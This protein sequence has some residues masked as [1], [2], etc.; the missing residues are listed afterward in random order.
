MPL[1]LSLRQFV[2]QHG[3]VAGVLVITLILLSA[4]FE[5]Y[6]LKQ[7]TLAGATF[8]WG[9][10]VLSLWVAVPFTKLRIFAASIV[11]VI[12]LTLLLSGVWAD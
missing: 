7:R 10:T 8:V 4:W 3:A 6:V 9:L 5:A 12:G 1:W 2:E 11:F